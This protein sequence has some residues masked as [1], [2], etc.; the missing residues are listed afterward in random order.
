MDAFY[1]TKFMV[2][3]YAVIRLLL[4]FWDPCFWDPVKP[5]HMESVLMLLASNQLPVSNQ[6]K[7]PAMGVSQLG[8]LAP[9]SLKVTA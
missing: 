8:H 5:S 7:F 1:M 2:I 9:M 6:H 4:V 3:G